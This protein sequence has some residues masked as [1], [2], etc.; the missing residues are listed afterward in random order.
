QQALAGQILEWTGG[1]W[2]I[3]AAGL[4]VAFSG[5]FQIKFVK[6]RDH[7]RRL[8]MDKLKG[9]PRASATVMAWGGYLGRCAILLVLGWFLLDAALS[10]DPRAVGDTD[11]AFDFLGL[12][13]SLLG[14]SVFTLVALGTIFY[15]IFMYINAVYF[16]FEGE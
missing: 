16:K 5:L 15:G 3:G 14:D 2:L 12:G 4:L 1:R 6:D 13:G 11:T 8:R 7:E 9:F 10:S